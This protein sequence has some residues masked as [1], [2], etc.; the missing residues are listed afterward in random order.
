M[1]FL[2]YS[3]YAK[4]VLQNAAVRFKSLVYTKVLMQRKLIAV[5]YTLQT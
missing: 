4:T 3:M 2:L 1:N 5:T